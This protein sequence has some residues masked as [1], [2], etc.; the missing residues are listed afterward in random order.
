MYI[1]INQIDLYCVMRLIETLSKSQRRTLAF[2][3]CLHFTLRGM[4][5]IYHYS[6][7]AK[8]KISL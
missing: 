2:V 1:L 5:H 8:R 4:E 6:Q 3:Y 7:L